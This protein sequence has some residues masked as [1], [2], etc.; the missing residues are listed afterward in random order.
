MLPTDINQSLDIVFLLSN[1]AYV[2]SPLVYGD[3]SL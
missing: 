3:S 1:D 2:L